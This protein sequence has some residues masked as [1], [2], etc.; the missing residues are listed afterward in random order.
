MSDKNREAVPF[1]RSMLAAS[2]CLLLSS[3][4][5]FFFRI[6]RREMRTLLHDLHCNASHKSTSLTTIGS[7]KRNDT[8]FETAGKEIDD[9]DLLHVSPCQVVVAV[10]DGDIMCDAHPYIF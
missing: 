2:F 10:E 4:F 5:F 1:Y 7:C 9:Q 6:V 3:D 8:V